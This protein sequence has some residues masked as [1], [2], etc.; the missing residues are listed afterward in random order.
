MNYNSCNSF[1]LEY[2]NELSTRVE[3]EYQT[4]IEKAVE[5]R[6]QVHTEIEK[7]RKSNKEWKAID[8]GEQQ[9]E[10]QQETSLPA[11][12]N[13]TQLRNILCQDPQ[14]IRIT[15]NSVLQ[16]QATN[17]TINPLQVLT[18]ASLGYGDN[19]TTTIP[20]V[21]DPNN[22]GNYPQ[23]AFALDSRN[24]GF[25]QPAVCQ[26]SVQQTTILQQS[27]TVQLTSDGCVVTSHQPLPQQTNPVNN[28][29]STTNSVAYNTTNLVQVSVSQPQQTQQQ[30]ILQQQQTST[31]FSQLHNIVG[32][33]LG[34]TSYM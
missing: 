29:A 34:Q 12:T 7:A 24:I 16:T 22:S 26:G 23:L 33:L 32:G 19:N 13:H 6:N 21:I 5:Q 20:M 3:S 10:Q 25:V 1:I 14:Q 18:A 27:N 9:E 4:Q 8:D 2:S 30:Q 28:T 15:D 11:A 17:N 31:E